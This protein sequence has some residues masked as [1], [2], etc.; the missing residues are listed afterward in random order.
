MLYY[1]LMINKK[2]GYKK[3]IFMQILR[4]FLILVLLPIVIIYM[5]AKLAKSAKNKN[6]EKE[7]INFYNI[8]Q[9]DSLSGIEFELLLKNLFEKMGCK[10]EMTKA[11]GDFGADLIIEKSGNKCVVQAKRYSGTV[12]VSAVQEVVS[13]KQHYGSPN[14]MVV[15]NSTFSSEA[16]V[17]AKECDIDLV[18]RADLEKLIEKF[19]V[20]IEMVKTPKFTMSDSMKNEMLSKY[21]F[22]I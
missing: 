21:K 22:W 9:I 14:A 3:S 6:R 19:G 5:A 1:F 4:F 15:T 12:G 16:K 20:K 10:V 11:S 2:M 7:L 13:S 18:D 17:L 8:T